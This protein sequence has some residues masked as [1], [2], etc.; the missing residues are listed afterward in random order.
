MILKVL[1]LFH[2]YF[3]LQYFTLNVPRVAFEIHEIMSN[4][5]TNGSLY[6]IFIALRR[7]MILNIRLY[8]GRKNDMVFYK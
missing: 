7:N 1:K 5:C 6:Q 4:R 3:Q 8:V 2:D